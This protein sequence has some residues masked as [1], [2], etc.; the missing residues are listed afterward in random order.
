MERNAENSAKA[1]SELSRH[2]SQKTVSPC[3]TSFILDPRHRSSHKLHTENEDGASNIFSRPELAEFNPRN[4][5]SKF[6]PTDFKKLLSDV[7]P[8]KADITANSPR[9]R[10]QSSTY[11][12]GIHDIRNDKTIFM[13]PAQLYSTVSGR[14]FHSGQIAIVLVG[15]PARGKTYVI[16][17]LSY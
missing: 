14:L 9:Y 11:T 1:P 10:R 8:S 5:E 3:T 16:F 7:D 12:D 13:A 4:P 2:G 6:Q 15:L 17:L